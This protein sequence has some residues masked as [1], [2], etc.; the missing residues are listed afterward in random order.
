MSLQDTYETLRAGANALALLSAG[1]KNLELASVKKSLLEH[2]P[3]ILEAN[4]R[5]VEKAKQRGIKES[6]IDRLLL[7]EARMISIL[8]CIDAII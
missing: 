8:S 5:D 3:Q 2:I 4:S 6:L 7:T 1:E